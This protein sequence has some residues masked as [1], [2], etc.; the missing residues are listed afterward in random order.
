MS[1][2]AAPKS[3]RNSSG[4]THMTPR[5]AENVSTRPH[6]HGSSLPAAAVKIA[7]GEQ[8]AQKRDSEIN[9]IT[10][11]FKTFE[12]PQPPMSSSHPHSH[13][14]TPSSVSL[15][16][17]FLPELK[18]YKLEVEASGD[19][20]IYFKTPITGTQ[21]FTISIPYASLTH[22]ISTFFTNDS[23]PSSSTS[24]LFPSP[25][26]NFPKSTPIWHTLLHANKGTHI[27]L[28][29]LHGPKSGTLVAIDATSDPHLVT[30][31]L[32]DH[33][34]LHVHAFDPSYPTPLSIQSSPSSLSSIIPH[35]VPNALVPVNIQ[36]SSEGKG[37]VEISYGIVSATDPPF[38]FLYRLH[39]PVIAGK[40]VQIEDLQMNCTARVANPLNVDIENIELTLSLCD[41]RQDDEQIAH[42]YDDSKKMSSRI[43]FQKSVAAAVSA[44][45]A[46]INLEQQGSSSNQN[47]NAIGNSNHAESANSGGMNNSGNGT[48]PIAVVPNHHQQQHSDD[49]G[50][51]TSAINNDVHHQHTFHHPYESDSDHDSDGSEYDSDFFEIRSLRNEKSTKSAENGLELRSRA[52]YRPSQKVTLRRNQSTEVPLQPQRVKVRLLH[53]FNHEWKRKSNYAM[54]MFAIQGLDSGLEHGKVHIT[55]ADGLTHSAWIY[56]SQKHRESQFLINIE[57]AVYVKSDERI[58]E[59][60]DVKIV[61]FHLGV[62]I[63]RQSF[64]RIITYQV[65][66][67]ERHDVR[68]E[69]Y[70]WSKNNQETD[71]EID[72]RKYNN[73]KDLGDGKAGD[74][75]QCFNF[76]VETDRAVQLDMKSDTQCVV[77]IEEVFH[78]Q[79]RV[80]VSKVGARG[81]ARLEKSGAISDEVANKMWEIYDI[82][83]A[84]RRICRFKSNNRVFRNAIKRRV[85]R[86][87][88]DIEANI[89]FLQQQNK[90][91]IVNDNSDEHEDYRNTEHGAGF[92]QKRS[93]IENIDQSEGFSQQNADSDSKGFLDSDDDLL[94]GVDQFVRMS[95]RMER[96]VGKLLKKAD[97]STK[98]MVELENKQRQ[99]IQELNEIVLK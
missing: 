80:S 21:T 77:V 85:R 57:T 72:A 6:A 41:F 2:R 69:L 62:I 94:Q 29:T 76:Q 8:G 65:H 73:L 28:D 27:H 33:G 87:T 40:D 49:E 30:V 23:R 93:H 96:A 75:L 71:D 9:G 32:H 1:S 4:S 70:F 45:A 15:G 67:R 44:A 83:R 22:S 5:V 64:Q 26:P 98:A 20:T 14:P 90:Q 47:S 84:R 68:L 17:T 53:C 10:P 52:I 46:G 58:L 13:H 97:E 7:P 31:V 91:G 25:R 51:R 54:P 56:P 89:D 59:Q 18:P 74:K 48:V 81:I 38:D 43:L 42:V 79:K 35:A 92:Y 60:E 11:C 34:R 78:R 24:L 55:Y 3:S 50:N 99:I 39:L 63:V 61:G 36:C 16:S 12:Y 37:E 82:R 95:D 88:L 66:N 86:N 19:S